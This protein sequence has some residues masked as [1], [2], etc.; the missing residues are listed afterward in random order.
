MVCKYL[1][2]NNKLIFKS[3]TDA[4]A[5]C[6]KVQEHLFFLRKLNSL[7]VYFIH[8]HHHSLYHVCWPLPELTVLCMYFNVYAVFMTPA[9]NLVFFWDNKVNLKLLTYKYLKFICLLVCQLY[10]A[11]SITTT[12]QPNENR[13][14]NLNLALLRIITSTVSSFFRKI[15]TTHM[16]TH[17]SHV[18]R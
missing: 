4:D 17:W 8:H 9:V 2:T 3:N 6:T 7:G 11:Y 14:L 10:V 15:S 18:D 1:G 12:L 16:M 5:V 13:C